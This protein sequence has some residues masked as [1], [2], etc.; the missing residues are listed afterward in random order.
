[1]ECDASLAR[2][3]PA[4]KG[5]GSQHCEENP[6]QDCGRRWTGGEARAEVTAPK[7]GVLGEWCQVAVKG[8]GL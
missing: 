5:E 8:G 6:G 7:L 2:L 1:M 3:C 4:G